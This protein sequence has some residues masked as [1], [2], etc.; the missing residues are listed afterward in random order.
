MY[1]EARYSMLARSHPREARELLRLAEDDIE[2]QWRVY[3]SRASMA[4]EGQPAPEL[5][6]E[7][8]GAAVV[9][10]KGGEDE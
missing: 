8:A 4:G 6:E 1:E 2:R 9:V 10:N 5:P 3:E 7:P